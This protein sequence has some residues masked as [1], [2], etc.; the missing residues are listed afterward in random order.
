M[1][2][3]WRLMWRAAQSTRLAFKGFRKPNPEATGVATKAGEFRMG[4]MRPGWSEFAL[5]RLAPAAGKLGLRDAA[6]A[7]AAQARSASIRTGMAA[8]VLRIACMVAPGVGF[9]I[10]RKGPWNL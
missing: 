1:T 8:L 10:P 9:R 3:A 6:W 2:G 4:V 7:H 5:F